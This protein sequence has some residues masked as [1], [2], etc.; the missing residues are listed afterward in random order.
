MLLLKTVG[1]RNAAN[2]RS[3]KEKAREQQNAKEVYEGD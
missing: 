3:S 2:K 1:G